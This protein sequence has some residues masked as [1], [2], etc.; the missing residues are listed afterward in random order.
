[1]ATQDADSGGG[2]LDPAAVTT[3]GA[4][5]RIIHNTIK[6]DASGLRPP[7][8]L[9]RAR[10]LRQLAHMLVAGNDISGTGNGITIEHEGLARNN[11]VHDLGH[12][13]GGPSLRPVDPRGRQ[14]VVFRHNTALLDGASYPGGGG[15]SGALAVYSDFDHAQNVI[16]V[17]NFV[18]GG[19]YVIYGG[20]SGDEVTRQGN[21]HPGDRQPVRVR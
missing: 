1:M 15:L 8:A 21:R 5:A 18:S 12:M 6:R 11:W 3:T 20:N 19:S 4:N 14:A 7:G 2:A 17:D 16:L 13:A 9:R 10:L